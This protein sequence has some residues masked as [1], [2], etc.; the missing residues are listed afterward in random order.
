[1]LSRWVTR[2]VAA[3]VQRVPAPWLEAQQRRDTLR[4]FHHAARHSR[5]YADLLREAG[6][7][8]DRVVS[9][10]DF[11]ARAPILSKQNTFLRF[12]LSELCVVPLTPATIG[13]VLTSSGQGGRFGFGLLA[14]GAEAR[15]AM[16][17]DLGLDRTFG[18][19]RRPTL[20]VNCLPMGVT[21]TSNATT[22]AQTS[23]REDMALALLDRVGPS[24]EQHIVVADPLFAKRLLDEARRLRRSL[25]RAHFILGEE[26]FGENFR[27]FV[28]R[29]AGIRLDDPQ[30]RLVLSSMG[31]GEL[32]LNLFFET[33]ATV[34]LRRRARADAR[35]RHVLY[36]P[37]VAGHTPGLFAL[38]PLRTFVEILE[39]DA[40]GFG[41]L[42]I[43][44]LGDQLVPLP[45][46]DTGDR[47]RLIRREA[48]GPDAA[49]LPD[50]A[51]VLAVAGRDKDALPFGLHLSHFKE[52][53]YADP[54]IAEHL[55]GA[56]HLE[57]EAAGLRW[58]VQTRSEHDEV[59]LALERAAPPSTTVQLWGPDQ[60]PWATTLDYERKL[61]P[62][63]GPTSAHAPAQRSRGG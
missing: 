4:A 5:A 45:R 29:S 16:L 42:V 47:A 49:S 34:A 61:T 21:F 32:G 56:F 38:N 15:S 8:A 11:T 33:R 17:I 52:A 50:E 23:V 60:F 41:R 2:A 24:Y 48:L 37:D 39:P 27:D 10:D 55:T 54:V 6:V 57:P 40:N 18:V 19:F 44:M 25:E 36:G 46:Y 22:V 3:A 14:R 26:T 30:S 31:V 13:G 43:T 1:M 53:L 7:S 28:A 63:R 35:L 58:H 12:S 59:R 9:L 62:W 20:V 51:V